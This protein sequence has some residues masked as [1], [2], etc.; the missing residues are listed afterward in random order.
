MKYII[1]ASFALAGLL[2]A[3]P[4]LHLTQ[5]GIA[6][7]AEIEIHLDQET[8]AAEQIG[9]E[10]KETWLEISPAWKGK[11]IWIEANVLKFIPEKAPELG[12]TYTFSLAKGRKHID[13]SEVPAGE[14]GKESTPDHG[15]VGSSMQRA[16]GEEWS[17]R[18]AQYFLR[19]ND[20]VELVEVA[21]Y[22]SYESKGG[23]RVTAIA[24]RATKKN[25][26]YS[27]Y[28]TPTY[29]EG[30]ERWLAKKYQDKKVAA[31]PV[32]ESMMNGLLVRPAEPLPVG[33][34]WYLVADKGMKIGEGKLSEKK[35]F[36]VGDVK[37][38]LYADAYARTIADEPRHMALYFN[39]T[40]SEELV[41]QMIKIFPE[42]PGMKMEV[43]G[44]EVLIEGDFSKH[45]RWAVTIDDGLTSYDGLKI[46][47]GRRIDLTF[48]HLAPSVGVRSKDSSQ[49]AMGTRIYP[50]NTVNCESVKVRI[51]QLRDSQ[52]IRAQQ[53]YRHYTGTVPDRGWDQDKMPVPYAMMFGTTV[54]E[55]EVKLENAIDTSTG[56]YLDWDKV[57]AGDEKPYV[58][59][60]PDETLR[61]S[62]AKEPGAF[63]VEL[64]GSPRDGA[65]P[66]KERIVQSLVQLTDLGMG[67]K[68]TEDE[69]HVFAFSCET[70]EPLEGVKIQLYGEDAEL[71]HH[72]L[73][74]ATG[75]AKLPR[76]GK[77]RHLRASL[78]KDQYATTYDDSMP[79]VSMWRFPI[80]YSWYDEPP[81]LSKMML[82]TERSLYRP[83]EMVYLKG[84]LR[85]SKAGDL[86]HVKAT[87]C[88]L[89]VESPTGVEIVDQPLEISANGS[90][91][92]SFRLPASTVGRHHVTV[93]WKQRNVENEEYDVSEQ[94]SLHVAEFR[95]N[96]F[97][98]EHEMQKPEIGAK[99]VKLD[100]SATYY[101][102]QKV[103]KGKVDV[104]NN[105]RVRNFYPDKFR[106][107]LFGDHRSSDYY[108]WYYYYGYDFGYDNSQS[109]SISNNMELS[110]DGEAEISV[111]IPE[112]KFPRTRE[113]SIQTEVTDANRQ[114]LTRTSRTTVHPSSIYVGIR[115]LDRLV[116]VGDS[117]PLD[118]KAVDTNGDGFDGEVKVTARLT[119]KV[120]EQVRMRTDD[121]G[122]SVRND[123]RIEEVSTTEI[124]LG[125][126]QANE[127]LFEPKHNGRYTLELRGTDAQGLEFATSARYYVYGANDY[128]WAYEDNM[129]IK[130][131]SEKKVY[132]PGDT[133]RVL[134]LSPIEG[135]ALVT[136]ERETVS[137]SMVI[138]LKASNPILEFPL[139]DEDAPNC[140]VSVLIIKG[141]QDS[142]RAF[143]EPQLRLGY[144]ELTVKNV[145]DRLAV[146]FEKIE[147]ERSADPVAGELGEFMPGSQVT[148]H[149]SV[150][151]ADGKPATGA[152][153]TVYAVDEGTLAVSGYDTPDPMSF[154][155]S[156]RELFVKSGTS[157]GNFIPED[158][159]G[160]IYYN[161]GFF[162][163]GGDGDYFGE[164]PSESL[165]TRTDFNPCAFWIPAAIVGADGKF[166]AS[167]K[168]PD[169]LT[170]YRLIA[171]A[172][173]GAV[174][175]GHGEESFKVNKPLM[176]EPQVPRF[177]NEG[178]SLEMRALVQNA[179]DVDGVWSV[180]LSPNPPASEPMTVLG[181]GV[182]STQT[183]TLAAGES[184]TVSFRVNFKNTGE[185]RMSW[186]AVPVIVAGVSPDASTRK[187]HS[188]L[189]ESKFP[190]RYPMPLLRQNQ[191]VS[192]NNQNDSNDLLKNLDQSLLQ[193]T[194]QLDV[195]IS[196]S[197]LLEA[198]GAIDYLL[199]YPYGCVEQTTSSMLP[200]LA[201]DELRDVSPALA[202][203]TEEEVRD[204]VQHGVNRLLSMQNSDGGFGY[205][206]ASG[207]ASLWS[208]SYAT[209]GLLL[210]Q[211]K[212]DVPER[213]IN[214]A[215]SFLVKNLR[216]VDKDSSS[217]ELE[218]AA[219]N[220]W[221][222]AI[223]GK[224][225]EA[226]MNVLND[227][228]GQLNTQARCYLAM[229]EFMS[230]DKKQALAIMNDKTRFEER[231]AYW[232][233]WQPDMAMQLM[234]WS[235]IDPG[236]EQ[237]HKSLERLMNQRN[238]YGHWR[239][240]WANSWS[241]LAMASYAKT[242]T[243]TGESSL[244]ITGAFAEPKVI[245]LKGDKVID[246]FSMSLHDGMKLAASDVQ[247]QVYIR[248]KLASKP[249][250]G[251]AKPVI[252]DTM[253]LARFYKKV[254]PDGS[255]EPLGVP[256]IGDLIRVD[257]RVDLAKDDCRYLVIEDLL[258]ANFEAVN[259]SFESQAA[260][261]IAAG[262]V[263]NNWRVSHTEIR[264][265]RVMFFYDRIYTR[266]VG[267]LSY[268]ARCTMDGDSYAPPAKLESMYEP[269]N[270]ALTAGRHFTVNEEE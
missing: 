8:A 101:Q 233:P 10:T 164:G 75:M 242:E 267:T 156:P 90:I 173:E 106:D 143:K 36:R 11:T 184:T 55:F 157:L 220:L 125:G 124:V 111:D 103:A 168:L 254:N 259:N 223:A 139:T 265:D 237:C 56:F 149:G 96:A 119:R 197:L 109:N 68:I 229:S 142:R 198:G 145:K 21:P 65:K 88:R 35:R 122:S 227:R 247:G 250:I 2:D 172:H 23:Q 241:L 64:I 118:I 263:R 61:Q 193:G 176:L 236:S 127:Y 86:S 15:V 154:F 95:R 146:N 209:L 246:S 6:A 182:E 179:S 1:I 52:L 224:P 238:P 114:T 9:K 200:W 262:Q 14:I 136:V 38:F 99:V 187:R 180:S 117:I 228:I 28:M 201:V 134:V 211:E 165:T 77:T 37:P 132:Q 27:R 214:R 240:T 266:G 100:L 196:R 60:A 44:R 50:V 59:G 140:F 253:Q 121:G 98:I 151:L 174:R 161:K 120:N 190:V 62:A 133:A 170:R 78:G 69:A 128:P 248:L 255:V 7:G 243:H 167:V 257:L 3:A 39:S 126:E 92:H 82:F 199:N 116:R 219:R 131:V 79:T 43:N 189:V 261:M 73:T 19:F 123:S 153:V 130:L 256:K 66:Y 67:W 16:N 112:L 81:R 258:P 57:M 160:H 107:F 31:Y 218:T 47:E 217:W 188:D 85:E 260:N 113:V 110:E 105:V 162:I 71:L 53:G 80:R 249:P 29:K 195:E 186:M 91:D 203:N 192:L 42:V 221:V 5:S 87:N 148:V 129:R 102:G 22:F 13:G 94:M 252:T 26:A 137:R 202:K 177:A 230:G 141:S 231:G 135:K 181:D 235:M 138:D 185:A 12:T 159:E 72:A 108:Y 40:P 191:L 104:W 226:Y 178:D 4:R 244:V 270:A 222:L 70:G 93:K 32:P 234:A 144:C 207:N 74:D 115:R 194:G 251:Q 25:I 268:L 204:A 54:A 20:V 45:D 97:E 63:F 239:T 41:A 171:V 48:Q 58:M 158:L 83:S 30:Y 205:W 89:I 212:A 210:A 225:Q 51:K 49:L 17:Y 18:T 213:S 84:I 232:M 169:T 206:P 264:G 152:E 33:E 216:A 155:H 215:V 24:Q 46:N 76:N 150:N 166:S 208:T 183:V 147:G 269:E 163:G 245:E 175:F 34:E